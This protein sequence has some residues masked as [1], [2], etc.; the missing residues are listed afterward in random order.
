MYLMT[1]EETPGKTVKFWD[2]QNFGNISL[3]D[4][5]LGPNGLA[6]NAHLKGDYA[7]ISHYAS[8]LRI[9]NIADPSN[10]FE[11]GYY[12]TS[13][14]WGT[15]PYFPSGK[16]L[17]SDINDGLYI[18]FF[19]G[20]REGE[21]L[22]PNPPTNVVAY[23][24]YTT[25]TSIL[26]T[27]DD[28]TSLFNGDTLTPGEF[29]I[30]V[31]RDGSL[32]TSVPGGTET[33]T[34][35]GLT[36]GQV[37]TYTLF[38]RVLA[39]DSTSRDVSVAWYAGGS[40]VPAAP[41]N[42]QCD[43]G[44]TYAILTWE[45][46]TTQDDGTPLDD[47]DSIRVYRNGAHIAS[48]A[49]GTQ[50]Y[51]DTPPQGFTYTY[52][53]RA[54]DNETPPNESASSNTVECFV[55]DVPPFLVWVG[56]DASGASAESG[57]SIFAALVANGQGAFLTNDLFEFGNDLSPY[58]AIFVVLGIYSNNHVLMDPEGSALQTYLQ[59]GGRIYLEGGDCFNYDPDA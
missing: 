39:T 59:N 33:Y 50:T 32:V 31:W 16:V 18:V 48:V 21:P 51:T 22:D 5:Y 11:E 58:Q 17:I 38:S 45:D 25:P 53:V 7:Y 56:P 46:P 29:V 44:P 24:D 40:P 36:D 34:D 3:M 37:Y 41:A 10:I 30:D 20:A 2:I 23:S 1:T 19:E 13:D 6:H 15:W 26:L 47:L 54:L 14:D 28:P 4:T 9:V 12:D 57:D 43:T 27:W 35:G 42:L 49:P 8:G 52:E 55:G